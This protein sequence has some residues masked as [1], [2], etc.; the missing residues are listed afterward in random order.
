[1]GRFADLATEIEN[2]RYEDQLS[3]VEI[4]RRTGLPPASVKAFV[5][6]LDGQLLAGAPEVLPPTDEELNDMERHYNV[7]VRY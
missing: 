4:S 5:L 2:M 1:M 6:S 3:I 7:N